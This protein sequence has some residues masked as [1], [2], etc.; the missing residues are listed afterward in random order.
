MVA[1]YSA[2]E[3]IFEWDNLTNWHVALVISSAGISDKLIHN[4]I[5]CVFNTYRMCLQIDLTSR[6]AKEL[7]AMQTYVIYTDFRK[8]KNSNT[9]WIH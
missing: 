6:L 7:I 3:A 1:R 2:F 9:I 8:A 4:S 5:T